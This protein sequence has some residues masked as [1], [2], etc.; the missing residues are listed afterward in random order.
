MYNVKI[1][2]WI[3]TLL[4]LLLSVCF[5]PLFVYLFSVGC[6][7]GGSDHGLCNL[8]VIAVD[9]LAVFSTKL[10]VY[11]VH[12]FWLLF[13]TAHRFVESTLDRPSLSPC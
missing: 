4:V 8:V 11:V 7:E 10:N 5:L 6:G 1:F 13:L 2:V 9:C 3:L 12:I